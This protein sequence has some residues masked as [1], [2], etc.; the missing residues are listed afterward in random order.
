MGTEY[1][2]NLGGLVGSNTGRLSACYATES[3]EGTGDGAN[4]GG[5]VGSNTGPL[6]ACYAIGSVEGTGDSAN[7]GGIVGSNASGAIHNSYF[8]RETSALAI[9]VGIGNENDPYS[10]DKKTAELQSLTGPTGIYAG[11]NLDIDGNTTTE[12]DQVVW[13]FCSN[14]QYPIL[15]VDANG[16]GQ[17]TPEEFNNPCGSNKPGGKDPPPSI[18]ITSMSPD[19]GPVGTKVILTGIGFSKIPARNRVIFN[20]VADL[21][22]DDVAVEILVSVSTTEITLRVPA[23]AVTGRIRVILEG[24]TATSSEDFTVRAEGS[25]FDVAVFGVAGLED[26][27]L[28]VYPNPA[29]RMIRFKGLSVGSRYTYLLYTITG[30]KALA[31]SLERETINI[32]ALSAGQYI[33][34]L[35]DDRLTEVLREVILIE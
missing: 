29:D 3:V 22:T 32:G 34:V 4:L 25:D 15:R 2:A 33:L 9:K 16:D 8:D 12:A 24:E 10:M 11:W 1:G 30:R 27:K 18:E 28:G 7:L 19:S 23:G 5:I 13:I 6:S 35:Q 31:G 14:D 21:S 20:G 26:G 17:A